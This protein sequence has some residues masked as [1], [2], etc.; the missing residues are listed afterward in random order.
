MSK[1]LIYEQLC[2]IDTQYKKA[3]ADACLPDPKKIALLRTLY[4]EHIEQLP[5]SDQVSYFFGNQVQGISP[6]NSSLIAFIV[7][8]D[9]P[10]INLLMNKLIAYG[11]DQIILIDDHS[12]Q[13]FLSNQVL[14]PKTARLS[15]HSGSFG[16]SKVLWIESICNLL[17]HGSWVATFDADEFIDVDSLYSDPVTLCSLTEKCQDFRH[18]IMR[19][20]EPVV[21]FCLLDVL[22]CKPN[23]RPEWSPDSPIAYY[24]NAS[25]LIVSEY[26]KSSAVKWSFG[27]NYAAQYITDLRYH[28]FG[29]AESRS[30]ISLMRW[31]KGKSLML[32]QGFHIV[33][34]RSSGQV[35]DMEWAR[36]SRVMCKTIIH[37]KILFSI[38]NPPRIDKLS[39]YFP[40]T[41]ENIKKLTASCA[42]DAALL[43]SS[44]GLMHEF[45]GTIY[46]PS[47]T[48]NGKVIYVDESLLDA[49]A[50]ALREDYEFLNVVYCVYQQLLCGLHHFAGMKLVRINRPRLYL[51]LRN[52]SY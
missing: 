13:L 23:H 18:Q 52:I 48:L 8:R 47:W 34:D 37:Q 25:R 2:E 27:K 19:S 16:L 44:V 49:E 38:L 40:R 30:K 3:L 14:A 43:L 45:R 35:F 50:N 22:P 51:Q 46:L 39:G 42:S 21:P 15:V 24:V 5:A 28:L 32:H 6:S 4:R 11:F 41:A 20:A 33:T 17:F 26:S 12:S 36:R 29:I 10:N 31:D 1:Q 9:E 7:I